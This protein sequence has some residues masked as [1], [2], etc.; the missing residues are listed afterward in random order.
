MNFLPAIEHLRTASAWTYRRLGTPSKT[1]AR[2]QGE[3]CEHLFSK[4]EI[5]SY[6]LPIPKYVITLSYDRIKQSEMGL[7]SSSFCWLNGVDEKRGN[8]A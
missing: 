5:K 8:V 4:V 2:Y 3:K 1:L 7:I 6:S